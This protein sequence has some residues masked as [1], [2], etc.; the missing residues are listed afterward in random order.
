MFKSVAVQG[1]L[2]GETIQNSVF[3][4][5]GLPFK[6]FRLETPWYACCTS[7]LSVHYV[8]FE[9]F[10]DWNTG[11]LIDWGQFMFIEKLLTFKLKQFL[12]LSVSGS[13]TDFGL[14]VDEMT[15]WFLLEERLRS[16]RCVLWVLP[17]LYRFQFV[18][19]TPNLFFVNMD[20]LIVRLKLA[21]EQMQESLLADNVLFALELVEEGLTMVGRVGAHRAIIN[22]MCILRPY[23]LI[24]IYG[25]IEQGPTTCP[26]SQVLV[27]TFRKRWRPFLRQSSPSCWYHHCWIVLGLLSTLQSSCRNESRFLYLSLQKGSQARL[28]RRK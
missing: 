28:G 13:C 2:L 27:P 5:F 21:F 20:F 3:P 9:L 12:A 8:S 18:Q 4:V 1:H 19:R 14:F 11:R 10:T 26:S 25:E 22:Y 6:W 15:C 24:G 7:Y 16:R 17:R 23:I